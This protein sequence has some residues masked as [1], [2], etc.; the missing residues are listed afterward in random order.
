[1]ARTGADG[2]RQP[3]NGSAGLLASLWFGLAGR[4]Y[5]HGYD[6]SSAAVCG[7]R[8][9]TMIDIFSILEI[10]QSAICQAE[11]GSRVL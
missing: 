10:E 1:M 2:T 4:R 11:G 6:E 8:G 9:V 3:E 7:S 5:G